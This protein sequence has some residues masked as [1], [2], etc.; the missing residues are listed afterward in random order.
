[1]H[2]CLLTVV[3]HSSRAISLGDYPR[4]IC[5]GQFTRGAIS[6][7]RVLHQILSAK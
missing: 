7:E 6:Q 1:M 3:F 2:A 4:T 5:S